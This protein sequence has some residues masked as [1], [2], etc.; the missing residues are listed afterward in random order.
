MA[1]NTDSNITRK[2]IRKFLPGFKS[3]LVLTNNV[4]RQIISNEFNPSSG[5]KVDVKRP[6]DYVSTTNATGDLTSTNR[7]AIISGKATATVQDFRTVSVEYNRLEEA[8]ELDQLGKP[9]QLQSILGPMATRL[10][11]DFERDFATFASAGAGLLSGEYGTAIGTNQESW[12]DVALAGA[13]LEAN[14]VPSDKMWDYFVNPFNQRKLASSQRSLGSGSDS[15]VDTAHE[16]AMITSN[17]AG[18][19]VFKTNTLPTYSS[20]VGADRVGT[21]VGNPDVTYLAAK[22]TMEQTL[23][24]IGFQAD[25]EIR[26]GEV[27][28]LPATFALDKS[29]RDPIIDDLGAQVTFTAVVTETVI[30]S[31]AGGGDIIIAGPA[32]FEADGAYN[33]VETAPVGTDTINLL[34]AASTKFQPNLFWHPDAFGVGFVDLPKLHGMD[35]SVINVDGISMRMAIDSDIITNETVLRVDILPALAVYNP[36]FAGKSFGQSA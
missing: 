28:E 23:T 22:D 33:T 1:N 15:L 35:N 17:L 2:L 5:D 26:A 30:L 29:T 31:G 8:I 7:S 4:N 13:T 16:R 10:A 18:M 6:H 11:T 21:L 19:D 3:S 32:I 14:G 20:Q 25:L 24:V 34:G 36:F 12:D 27:I 9:G